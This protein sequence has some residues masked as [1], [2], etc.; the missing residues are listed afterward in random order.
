MPV[1][2]TLL[3]G[4]IFCGPETKIASY[5]V[6]MGTY[7]DGG[8]AFDLSGEFDS[9]TGI[10]G[11]IS[12]AVGDL[13]YEFKLVGGTF[14]DGEGYPAASVKLAALTAGAQVAGSTDL[15]AIDD[16]IVTVFGK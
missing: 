6:E 10:S 7:T 16:L 14:A 9:V 1:T 3:H 2:K 11:N 5:K 12:G 4:P 8:E 15:S 13:V